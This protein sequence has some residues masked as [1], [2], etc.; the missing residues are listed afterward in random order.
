MLNRN[1]NFTSANQTRTY[2]EGDK[3]DGDKFVI[4]KALVVPG[5]SLNVPLE[6]KG[7]Q[8]LMLYSNIP[9]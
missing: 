8:N 4:A 7:L 2:I 6:N 1:K 3:V 5:A 9:R